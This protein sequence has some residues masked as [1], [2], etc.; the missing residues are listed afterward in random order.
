MT[1]DT[2]DAR[3]WCELELG[4]VLATS[5]KRQTAEASIGQR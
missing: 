4:A 1:D 3:V 5:G 2:G